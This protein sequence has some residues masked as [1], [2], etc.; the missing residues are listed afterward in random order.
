MGFKVQLL[1]PNKRKIICTYSLGKDSDKALLSVVLVGKDPLTPL[2][3]PSNFLSLTEACSL[4]ITEISPSANHSVAAAVL[5]I[6]SPFFNFSGFSISSLGLTVSSLV[7]EIDDVDGS[8]CDPFVAAAIENEK[9]LDLSEEQK[10]KFRKHFCTTTSLLSH[11]SVQILPP[12]LSHPAENA[13]IR[14]SYGILEELTERPGKWQAFGNFHLKFEKWNKMKHNHPNVVCGYWGWISM[15]NLP[16][17]YWCRKIFEATGAYFGGLEAILV[18]TLNHTKDE[19]GEALEI[20]SEWVFPKEA[21][22]LSNFTRNP[23]AFI[24]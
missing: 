14:L 7:E 24:P 10:K 22:E 8:S 18:E 2:S 15:R 13:L 20:N 1:D 23:F 5:D 9:E 3:I 19:E 16:L 11:D 4:Q 6:V 17:D 21:G 12:I